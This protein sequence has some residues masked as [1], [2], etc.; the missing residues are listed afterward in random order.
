MKQIIKQVLNYVELF[1]QIIYKIFSYIH[2]IIPKKFRNKL[3][4][5]IIFLF[6]LFISFFIF[7]RQINLLKFDIIIKYQEFISSQKSNSKQKEDIKLAKKIN[8]ITENIKHTIVA[9]KDYCIE[10]NYLEKIKE[11]RKKEV[12][13]NRYLK[14][15]ILLDIEFNTCNIENI[16]QETI[17]NTI[18]KISSSFDKNVIL[19]SIKDDIKKLKK[20]EN[21]KK[22]KIMNKDDDYSISETDYYD[23]LNRTAGWEDEKYEN[24]LRN[25]KGLKAVF[26]SYWH[27]LTNSKKISKDTLDP[28]YVINKSDYTEEERKKIWEYVDKYAY[29]YIKDSYHNYNKIT[30]RQLIE[31]IN[32]SSCNLLKTKLEK[33]WIK[34][35]EIGKDKLMSLSEK[36]NLINDISKQNWYNQTN[37]I[38]YELHSNS[39]GNSNKSGLEVF[40]SHFE[41]HNNNM[42]GRDL[43]ITVLNSIIKLHKNKSKVQSEYVVKPDWKSKHAYLGITSATKPL[44]MLIE[45]WFK[46]NINDITIM[47]EHHKEIGESIANGIIDFIE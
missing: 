37:S 9:N 10:K 3:Y 31:M 1:F 25:K 8:E 23:F 19:E 4:I 41:Q 40:Y 22:E 2:N 5:G 21:E 38:V 12:L 45:Y 6:V 27:W 18:S 17:Q 46:K 39:V 11:L 20:E 33:R 43:A 35:Y 42:Q 14:E 30:E 13:I 29:D 26:C 7:K 34:V 47:L 44:W 28:G 15:K 32:P 24:K 16:T 36:I